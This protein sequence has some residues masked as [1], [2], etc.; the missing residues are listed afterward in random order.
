MPWVVRRWHLEPSKYFLPARNAKLAAEQGACATS[1]RMVIVPWLGFMTMSAYPLWG[2]VVCGGEPVST[3][4]LSIGLVLLPFSA[5][6]GVQVHLA[7]GL[8]TGPVTVL[9]LPLLNTLTSSRTRPTTTTTANPANRPVLR[10]LR[11]CAACS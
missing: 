8:V 2:T 11:R 3:S 9:W 6:F 5:G 10:R 7:G 1:R 4:D